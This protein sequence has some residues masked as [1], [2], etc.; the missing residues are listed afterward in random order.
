MPTLDT[1]R[2]AK[3]LALAGSD[4]DGEALAA[5]RKARGMLQTAGMTFTDVAQRM[6]TPAVPDNSASF[7]DAEFDDLMR[8]WAEPTA[9][10]KPAPYVDPCGN[11]WGSKADYES[12][13]ASNDAR[14]ERD[15]Q[16]HAAERAAI[17][18]RYGCF[19][20]AA[21][22]DEREQLLHEAAMPWL[23][24]ANVEVDPEFAHQS[25]RWHKRMGGWEPYGSTKH[26]V[27]PCRLA[28]ENAY[29]MPSTI[30]EARDE[31]L[32][33]EQR[34]RE[35]DLIQEA[36]GAYEV[37]DLPAHYRWERVRRL[38]ES[39]LP[40]VTMDDLHIRLQF[41]RDADNTHDVCDAVPSIID[42]FE[43]LVMHAPHAT[44]VGA[45]PSR[46][47]RKTKPKAATAPA[48]PRQ[49]DL[50]PENGATP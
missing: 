36:Y 28:I 4:H 19:E 16:K 47:P 25:G 29:P 1:D 11:K 22:R 20:A 43:R 26:P 17:I 34:S 42:A 12:W 49:R 2:F 15:R 48:D 41:A 46:R 9:K 50:F 23:E 40:I 44:S 5:L 38:Y 7:T 37:L 33:W 31:H 21:A 39:E 3:V 14:F 13:K 45:P 35:L 10:K 8:Q 6:G 18:A 27:A 24:G 30:R 32:A